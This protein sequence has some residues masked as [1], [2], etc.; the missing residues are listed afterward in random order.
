MFTACGIMHPPYCRPVAWKRW[1]GIC[2]TGLLTACE[3]EHLL[4]LTSCQQICMTC[5]TAV[6]TVKKFLTMDRGT[7]RNV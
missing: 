3:Q 1:N 2:H 6:C 4:L 7:V 5:T